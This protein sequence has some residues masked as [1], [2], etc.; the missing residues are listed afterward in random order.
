MTQSIKYGWKPELPDFRDHPFRLSRVALPQK[1]DLRPSC[2][3]VVDQSSLGS[4]VSNAVANA[5][6]FNQLKQ[7]KSS[8]SITTFSPSR[9]FIYYNARLIEG[10]VPY[11]AGAYVRDGIKVVSKFGACPEPQWPYN[12]SKF[13]DRPTNPCYTTALGH[14]AISYQR[15]NSSLLNSMKSCLTDGYPFVFGFT[16]YKSFE[17]KIVE[18]T[19]IVPMPART[20]QVLGGHCV[21][22][23]G[24]DEKTQRFICMNSW[25]NKWGDKG[26]FYMPYPYLTNLNLA[27][28]FWTIRLVKT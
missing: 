17:S 12:I 6:L 13:T 21:M 9:L 1:I 15:L 23:V 14:T 19:G 2:P 8:P 7:K 22:C 26:Y 20:E 3:P 16:V 24:Y 25:G 18:T 28:D 5:H 11:D 4:C 27:D 10:T